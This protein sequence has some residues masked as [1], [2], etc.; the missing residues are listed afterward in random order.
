MDIF[1]LRNSLIQEYSNYIT[2]FLTIKD[3][4]I[5]S[6]VETAFAEGHLCP[7][8]LLQLNPSF[9]AAPTME[10]L[11]HQKVLHPKNADIFRAKDE[12]GWQGDAFRFHKHQADGF[13]A[14]QK[15]QNYVL[16]TGTGSGKSISYIVPIVDY[17]L[18]NGSG[19]GIKAII[20]YPMNALANSQIGE[21]SKFLNFGHD[22]PNIRFQRYTGQESEEVR[23]EILNNPPDILLT[24]YVMLELILTRPRDHKLIKNAQG[25]PFLVFDELHTYRGRQGADVAMLIRR[26]RENCKSPDMLTIGTSAT[27]SSGESWEE[28]QKEV[29]TVATKMFGSEVKPENVIGES[30]RRATQEIDFSIPEHRE[31]L[32][33]R[34]S[35]GDYSFGSSKDFLSD[36]LASWVE[37]TLGLVTNNGR[38]ERTKPRSIEGDDGVAVDLAKLTGLSR[39]M[40]SNAITEILTAGYKCKNTVGKPIFAFRL[41]QF[42]SKGESVYSTLEP[43]KDRFSTL[44]KQVYA[45][46]S[47]QQKLLLPI[48]FCRECGQDY[49]VVRQQIK[50]DQTCLVE[51][52]F[53]DTSEDSD[54]FLYISS[55]NPWATDTEEIK[56]RIPDSWIDHNIAGS[57]IL[58]NRRKD[59]PKKLCFNTKGIIQ[60]KGQVGWFVKAPFRFCLSCGVAYN[61]SQQSDFGKLAT[62]GSEGRSTATTIMGLASLRSLLDD[63][64]LE[65]KAKKLLSFTDNRQDASLQAGHFNDFVEIAQLR[66][67]LCLALGEHPKGISSEDLSNIVFDS[68]Q[69]DFADYAQNPEMPPFA[70]GD[71]KQAMKDVIGYNLFQD[72]RRGW[73]ITSPNLEQCGL[74]KVD[75][76][77]LIEAIQYEDLWKDR[78]VALA[79][80]SKD[81]REHIT[82]TLLDFMRR[83]LAID[84]DYLEGEYQAKMETRARQYIQSETSWDITTDKL[85]R[86]TVIKPRSKH[87]NDR[88]T[89][90]FMSARSGFGQ[91]LKQQRW[92]LEEKINLEDIET[93]IH[94]LFDILYKSG[95]LSIA[96][97]PQF[98]GDVPGYQLKGTSMIWHK[99]EGEQAFLDPIRVPNSPKEGLRINPYFK[100]F[101]QADGRALAQLE[102]REH[103]AQVPSKTREE[104]EEAFRKAALR[105]LFCSPTMELGVDISQLNVVNMRNVPPTPANYAQRSGRAGRSGQP[106]L[107][108][109]YCAAGSPHDQHFFRH[110]NLMV[111]GSVSTPRLDLAN[112]EM[113]KAHVHAIWLGCSNLN[114][115]RSLQDVLDVEGGNPSLELQEHVKKALDDTS[116]RQKAKK[117]ALAS[118]SSAILEL[119][120][121][122]SEVEN[123]IDGVL[124]SIP[125]SFENAC[126]R[127][128]SL[129]RSAL[130]QRDKQH[131]IEGDASRSPD[132]KQKA[133]R[134]RAEAE[135]QRDLLLENTGSQ[136][137]DFYSYRYFA[138]EGFLPGYNFPRL[139][140]SAYI[141]GSRKKKNVDEF[142][143]RSR[144]LAISEFG[145]RSI[146]YHEG[147]RYSINRVIL[148]VDGENEGLTRTAVRC[149]HCGYIHEGTGPDLCKGCGQN[150]SQGSSHFDNLFQMEN[151]STVK[152]ER[153]NSDEEERFRM[154]YDLQTAYRFANRNGRESKQIAILKDAQGEGLFRLTYGAAANIWR[155]NLGWRK[156]EQK[157][158]GFILD[159]ERGTWENNKNIDNLEDPMSEN[160][161]RV[162][163]FVYDTKNCLIFEPFEPLEIERMASLEAALKSAIQQNFQLEDRELIVESL[164][165][166]YD[167]QRILFYEASE[168]GAGVLKRIVEEPNAIKEVLRTALTL[169]HFDPN[170]FEDLQYSPTSKEECDTAC[171]DC[172]LSYFN[173]K[174]HYLV[175]RHLLV[176][177]FQ[178]WLDGTLHISPREISRGELYHQLLKKCDSELEKK[179]LK[180]IF[181]NGWNLP[182][183]GQFS[184]PGVYV[185]MDFA[186]PD[187][188][189]AIF[190]DG[191]PHDQEH[192]KKQDQEKEEQLELLGWMVLRFRYDA[193]W[194]TIFEKYKSIFKPKEK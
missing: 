7:K 189:I 125:L 65:D 160:I 85:I 39:E 120:E 136:F 103:T 108:Y 27:L 41:H 43:S 156:S 58:Q 145:P 76:K 179:W 71:V 4:V 8:P 117:I 153:I 143:T 149:N 19:K 15:R 57:P 61:F 31:N 16:T 37:S 150:L 175:D 176:D 190:I 109:T 162:I 148:P 47:N 146:I 44:H 78:H 51:R 22:I 152:R 187:Q 20:V 133:R 114:L 46:G 158:Q 80:S 90:I 13:L 81:V 9:E 127:W 48:V 191:P 116:S 123:W 70:Q 79:S 45:P 194:D 180:M 184:L 28:Q 2:S 54:G 138:S 87:K 128:R 147:N 23:Q 10:E 94:D 161:Q 84:I 38:L 64:S 165:D 154:G 86:A 72:L 100:E 17:V 183:E 172:L 83:E 129:F 74:L 53:R 107:V 91:F 42:I 178:I 11:I 121:E 151:V 134:F 113:L 99:G 36:P 171:Y 49:Y 111:S 157:Q 55:E 141:P 102:A 93:M 105:L 169:C 159:L 1:A 137:S 97:K 115:G 112:E 110:P 26:V 173:Q 24:N 98:E 6:V 164:P 18:R 95:I 40:C 30:L 75:Y 63:S 185:E 188:Q 33:Q 12:T 163:P 166:S 118:M 132:D 192:I 96:E 155:M 139:P 59:L 69:L 89:S 92:G 104:R 62:L 119:V 177:L 50:G 181:D 60:E 106:A 56:Q 52:D 68:L 167:R 174:D 77:H 73:R 101:Y 14:A 21:L 186:I 25:L 122:E 131:E 135:R 29:A 124:S 126:Q 34:I 140:L 170:T 182:T 67:A 5:R 168:G 66:S 144:F 130:K 88:Q 82:K 32:K 142:I 3:E 193:D 35:N